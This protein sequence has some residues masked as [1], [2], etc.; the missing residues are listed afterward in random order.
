MTPSI[1]ITVNGQPMSTSLTHLKVLQKE[2][3][4]EADILIYN[5]FA[6]DEDWSLETGDTIHLIRRGEM[7]SQDALE[8]LM[9]ARHTP[10]VHDTVKN[11]TVGI[12]GCGGLG[13][14]IA[15]ALARLGIGTLVLADFDIVEPSNLNRQAYGISHLGLAKTQALKSIIEDI[16]PYCHVIIHQ[17][18]LT[19]LNTAHYFS[20][21]SVV[22]EAFDVPQSKAML[23]ETLLLS[24][25]SV[26]VVAASGL[27]G[28]S[29]ANAITTTQPFKRLYVVGDKISAA[30][31]GEG[32]MAPRVLVAAGHQATMVL[33][34]LMGEITP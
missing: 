31:P 19:P 22:V 28:L 6:T 21:C 15:I 10:K 1:D 9:K 27:A 14:H 17:E 23:V 16:N 7:P 34:L 4:P 26:K 25:K 12:A 3:Y 30:K 32:L 8:H 24:H 33:R 2:V 29:S 20:S 5:G 11:A 18:K 13:S